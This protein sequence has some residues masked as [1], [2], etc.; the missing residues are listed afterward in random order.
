MARLVLAALLT[1]TATALRSYLTL[2][3]GTKVPIKT[4]NDARARNYKASPTAGIALQRGPWYD[5]WRALGGTDAIYHGLDATERAWLQIEQAA[6]L[7]LARGV[8]GPLNSSRTFPADR[9][10]LFR[11]ALGAPFDGLAAPLPR[12]HED[13]QRCWEGGDCTPPR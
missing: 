11:R 12:R 5:F 3:D 7:K 10:A 8:P 2:P 13:A 4:E 6:R 9:L 1:T